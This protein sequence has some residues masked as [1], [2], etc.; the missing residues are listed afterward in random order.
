[1]PYIQ[2]I[3]ES[4]KSLP[5]VNPTGAIFVSLFDLIKFKE[6]ERPTYI[7]LDIEGSIDCSD[8]AK[9]AFISDKREKFYALVNDIINN[10]PKPLFC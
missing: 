3:L 4:F 9:F 6:Q 1:M 7:Y 10:K 2:G 8:L 5:R